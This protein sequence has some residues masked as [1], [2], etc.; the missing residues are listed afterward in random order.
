M[1]DRETEWMKAWEVEEDSGV[2]ASQCSNRNR[3][4]YSELVFFV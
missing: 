3:R 4:N 1:M 2:V